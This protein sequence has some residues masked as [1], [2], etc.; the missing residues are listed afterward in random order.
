MRSQIVEIA[1]RRQE[2]QH[3]GLILQRYLTKQD[4]PEEHRR[5]F[6]AVIGAAKSKS[7]LDIYAYAYA[8]W[9]RF[10]P[11]DGLNLSAQLRTAGRLIVGLGS[12]SV[13]ETGL[14]L[15]HTYGLP[16]I[17]GSALKGLA[18]HYCHEIWGQ[19]HVGSPPEENL[20]F[21]RNSRCHRL[22][23]GTTEDGGVI[24]FHDAWITPEST[25]Q[26]CLCLDVMTP[27][28]PKWQTNQ[29]PPTD[30]DSPVPVPFLSVTGTFQVRISWRGPAR[31]PRDRAE[32][33]TRLAMTLL[34][35]ALADWGIG[36]KTSS[37]YGRLISVEAVSKALPQLASTAVR[38]DPRSI[39]HAGARVEGVLLDE[40]TKKGGWKARHDPSGLFG[41]I[42]NSA[43]IPPDRK[44]GDI[45]TLIVASVNEREIA[46]RYPT[47][48]DDRCARK[49]TERPGGSGGRP[50]SHRR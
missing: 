48:E 43:D 47:E 25:I 17:P 11:N 15:H 1:H 36:G 7:L 28:H 31:T 45:L 42:Q 19:A 22:L 21:R 38:T 9:N 41:P 4:D 5:L 29:A 40:K 50:L 35:Q 26:G 14:T 2:G 10:F 6:L 30:F 46:F 33:W 39:P 20:N 23:F 37:G 18:S 12:D 49:G 32:A 44:P 13:L 8:R 27:H 34:Q 16:L 3:P 24:M